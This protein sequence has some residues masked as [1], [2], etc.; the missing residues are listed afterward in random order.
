MRSTVF[1]PLS[2][3]SI[4]LIA[5]I[6][7]VGTCWCASAVYMY[8]NCKMYSAS[9]KCAASVVAL[10][11][12]DDRFES[13]FGISSTWISTWLVVAGL[14]LATLSGS[15][16]S[17]YECVQVECI[18]P[19]DCWRPM[20]PPTYVCSRPTTALAAGEYDASLILVFTVTA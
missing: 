14:A 17:A 13:M 2:M 8:A 12:P 1:P 20:L 5:Q 6:K 19:S 16:T 3:I 18:Q 7:N 10:P 11:K 9:N 15:R 4:R